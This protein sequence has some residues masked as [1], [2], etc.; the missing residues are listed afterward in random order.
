MRYRFICIYTYDVNG[1]LTL[2]IEVC[3]ETG[4]KSLPPFVRRV[5]LSEIGKNTS[6]CDIPIRA[7]INQSCCL[8]Q[9]P[10]I[11]DN[12]IFLSDAD[13][14]SIL[15]SRNWSYM[16]SANNSSLKKCKCPVVPIIRQGVNKGKLIQGEL[17][18]DSISSWNRSINVRFRYEGAPYPFY[19]DK[20]LSLYIKDNGCLSLRDYQAEAQLLDVLGDRYEQESG[21]LNLS[22]SNASVELNNIVDSGWVLFIPNTDSKYSRAYVRKTTS[23]IVWFSTENDEEDNST[24][25]LLDAFLK[26]RSYIES[27]SSISLFTKNDIL[28][29]PKETLAQSFGA[30]AE[31]LSLYQKGQADFSA[32]DSLDMLMESR[33]NAVLR[34]YQK[35]GVKWLHYH[36]MNGIGCLLADEMGLGKTVE[37]ISHLACLDDV[38]PYLVIA[39][40][41]LL[42]NWQKEVEKFAPF[43]LEGMTFIS[44]DRLRLHVDEYR[45]IEFDT[46]IVDEAQVVKNRDTERYKA[47]SLLKSKHRIILTG[48]PIEN[49]VDDV[50]SHFLFLNPGMKA[51]YYNLKKK[52]GGVDNDTAVSLSSR[53][54]SPFILRRTKEE[55]L[56]DLPEKSIETVYVNL[57]TTER[58][59]YDALNKMILYALQTGV[60]GRLNSIALEGL[61][62][63]RQAC[64]SVNLLPKSLSKKGYVASSKL[65]VAIAYVEQII[66]EGHKVLV[67]SQFVSALNE[68]GTMLE[69]R[70]IQYLC[71][72]G[73][74]VDRTTPVMSFQN[75]KNANKVFLISLKAGGV[76]LN[77]T[78]ASYVILLDEWWNPAVEEQAMARTHR[79]GQVSPVN[80]I[81]IV[82]KDTVEEKILEL[83]ERK[84]NVSDIFNSASGELSLDEI[85]ELLL[86]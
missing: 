15:S 16:K 76:G 2:R 49:S 72:F 65:N 26:G 80:V 1:K 60:S 55:V 56:D 50:W 7:L 38:G 75:D 54:L 71:L 18:V 86:L 32:V 33:V 37:V 21:V 23:G 25:L 40:V 34:P 4:H 5:D 52:C 8:D 68:F 42:C 28:N 29:E 63:L 85:K 66:S 69:D 9:S 82:C 13:V 53:L 3:H 22:D 39:P 10:F 74:T 79:I 27:P 73:S 59:V 70:D 17:Y 51:L 64:V 48:T 41:S 44:Y 14:V 45:N 57:S 83:Q 6:P 19:P 31:V 30:S 43:L 11:I 61:L 78:A 47:I 67:F 36:R 84:R 81:R 24:A 77:L 35:Y 62:R 58:Q 46:I 20:S 12:P